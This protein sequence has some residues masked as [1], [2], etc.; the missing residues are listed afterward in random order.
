MNIV[1]HTPT[2]HDEGES[3]PLQGEDEYDAP[4]WVSVQVDEPSEEVV[5]EY[6]EDHRRAGGAP[7]KPLEELLLAARE[8][9]RGDTE[10]KG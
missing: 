9:S 4:I 3:I 8:D 6:Y 2:I 7:I 5:L 1:E 10:A